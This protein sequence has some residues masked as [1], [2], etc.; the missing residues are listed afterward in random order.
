MWDNN[1]VSCVAQQT[2]RGSWSHVNLQ[3][4][5]AFLRSRNGTYVAKTTGVTVGQCRS[6]SLGKRRLVCEPTILQRQQTKQDL[7]LFTP[8]VSFNSAAASKLDHGDGRRYH[9][10]GMWSVTATPEVTALGLF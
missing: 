4:T 3:S 6:S 7:V 9:F 2:H 8:V 5:H 10:N 1:L